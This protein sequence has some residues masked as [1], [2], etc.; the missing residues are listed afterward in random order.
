MER[1]SYVTE[2][3]AIQLRLQNGVIIVLKFHTQSD[4][5]TWMQYIDWAIKL[6]SG[7]N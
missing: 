1:V 2:D 4:F 7:N 5:Q 3:Q 6:S